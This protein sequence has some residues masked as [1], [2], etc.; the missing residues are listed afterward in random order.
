MAVSATP[1]VAGATTAGGAAKASSAAGGGALASNSAGSRSNGSGGTG[2]SSSRRETEIGP[3]EKGRTCKTCP[4]WRYRMGIRQLGSILGISWHHLF[5]VEDERGR[6]PIGTH[7]AF[8][9]KEGDAG[10]WGPIVGKFT[11][12]SSKPIH[13][14]HETDSED[15]ADMGFL[16]P[17][18][19]PDYYRS[20]EYSAS[21]RFVL[22]EER[23]TSVFSKLVAYADGI[24][25]RRITYVPTGPN[26]NSYAMS[27]A[28]A[29]GLPR[30]KPSGDAPGSGMKL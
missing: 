7:S 3:K 6:D 1:I 25:K 19:S 9:S 17:K 2:A 20:G 27:L 13:E 14:N 29:A 24:L 16:A 11:S 26:S 5:L 30:K 28:E 8:P 21:N 22:L 18:F 15:E 4:Q 10:A 12:D 23:D